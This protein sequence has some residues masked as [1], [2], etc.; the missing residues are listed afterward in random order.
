MNKPK[1]RWGQLSKKSRVAT[2][3]LAA[4]GLVATAGGIAG[5]A[6]AAAQAPIT[7]GISVSLSGDFSGDGQAIENGYKLWA[8]S[9]NTHGG[10]LGRPVKLI[11]LNDAS[12]TTQVVTNYQTLI[13]VDH[14]N[15]VF[16]PFSS[17]LTTPAATI[18]NRYGYA[19][20][21]PAGGGPAVF[22]AHLP[23]LVFVQPTPVVDNLVSFAHWILSL[24]KSKR[25]KTA[26]YATEDDPFTQ[27]QLQVAQKILQKGGIK[28]VYFRV[29]PAETTDYSPIAD[30]V[31]NA[32]AQVVLLGTQLPD[33][34][35]F[36]QQ[37]EQQHYSPQTLV[38]TSGPDQGSQFA[39]AIGSAN[40]QGIMVPAGWWSG[41]KTYGNQ[42]FIKD[43]LKAYGG[44]VG[45]ISSDA[46]E[47]WSVGQV[48]QQAIEHNHSIDNQK[49]IKALH[50]MQFNTIQGPL[51]FNSVGEPNGESF[52]VQWQ[53]GKAVPVYPASLATASPLYPKPNWHH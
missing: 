15:L 31:I 26:A 14:V 27:P 3:A 24:P 2:A 39:N 35:A 10:L 23:N 32:K 33:A 6:Q 25:P 8:N 50:S 44:N 34:V 13:N 47:A 41:A 45:G 11:F 29:Y 17:L 30:G 19:F 52:L 43:Y 40:T 7:I 1:I 9:V 20:P 51:K 4:S 53:N 48:V 42:I 18:A 36:V 5:T 46:A 38:E 21:E 16:G 49:L 22:Q 28:T 12:S 37:F